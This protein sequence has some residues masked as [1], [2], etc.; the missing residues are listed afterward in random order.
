MSEAALDGPRAG[1]RRWALYVLLLGLIG[2]VWGG[3]VTLAQI[4]VSTGTPPLAMTVWE[5]LYGTAMLLVAAAATGRWPPVSRFWLIVYAGVA[6][7][8]TVLPNLFSYWAAFHLTGGLMALILS[9]IPMV[10]FAFA[11]A[12]GMD[13]FS[14][15]RVAGVLLGAA[16]IAALVLPDLVLG[17]GV[18]PDS[19][20][21]VF[22]LV[23]LV[24]SI[25]YAVEANFVARLVPAEADAVS[26][27][28]GS[29]VVGLLIAA[30]AAAAMGLWN[31]RA[32]P[33]NFAMWGRAEWALI[34]LTVGHVVAYS[35]YLWVLG[36][37]GAVFSS[38]VSYVVTFS[39]VV[40]SIVF[41]GEENSIWLWI[42]FALLMAGVTL[43]RPRG[44]ASA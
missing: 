11:V 10:T 5:L 42:A 30:P 32:A 31:D 17:E 24:P 40:L 33:W 25:S 26:L 12:L 37:A 13:A 39:G 27:L 7:F 14:P 44:H 34:G 38:Q 22:V 23:A 35:G 29:V 18:L 2:L 15:G 36:R 1:S 16:G 28:F 19:A 41:L 9:A 20:K 43:V 6:V 4:A 8:G 3:T 21:A